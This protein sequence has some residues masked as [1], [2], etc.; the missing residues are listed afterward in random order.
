V[1]IEDFIAK[2]IY[3]NFTNSDDELL[4]YKWLDVEV[5]YLVYILLILFFLVHT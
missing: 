4:N 1:G 5:K 2:E 3:D